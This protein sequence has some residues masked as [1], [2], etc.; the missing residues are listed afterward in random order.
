MTSSGSEA[1]F[2]R[3]KYTIFL[4]SDAHIGAGIQLLGGNLQGLRRDA[5]GFPFVPDTEIRGLLRLAGTHIRDSKAVGVDLF[6]NTF[7]ERTA[8]A[9]KKHGKWSF[10]AARYDQ[11]TRDAFPLTGASSLYK[12]PFE[13]QGSLGRQTHVAIDTRRLFGYQKMG[14]RDEESRQLEG[15]IFSHTTATEKEV[16]FLLACMR[17]DDRIGHRR[18]RGYGK[19]TWNVESVHRANDAGEWESVSHDHAYWVNRLL[20]NGEGNE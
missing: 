16:A 14:G 6:S 18:S 13:R 1:K 5:D 7:G 20:E 2:Y 15:L 19:V 3:V 17:M 12:G 11:D 4:Q 8:E 9:G 10:S